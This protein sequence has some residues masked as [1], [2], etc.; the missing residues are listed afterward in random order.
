M[1]KLLTYT[2]SHIQIIFYRCHDVCCCYI[3]DNYQL[4]LHPT[5]ME[6]AK[7]RGGDKQRKYGI[8]YVSIAACLAILS[9][10]SSKISLELKSGYDI[11]ETSETI[12]G[13]RRKTTTYF[14]R[15]S[16]CCRHL[17]QPWIST[18]SPM[19]IITFFSHTARIWTIWQNL[20]K[21]RPQKRQSPEDGAGGWTDGWTDRWTDV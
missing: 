15:Q 19:Q 4:Q 3:P 17:Q 2:T 12:V 7:Q 18:S 16:F 5:I 20:G 11:F 13:V 6:G 21:N 8:R 1:E 14:L 9:R 10:L